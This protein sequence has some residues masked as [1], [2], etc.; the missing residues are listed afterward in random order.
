MYSQPYSLVGETLDNRLLDSYRVGVSD[1]EELSVD[2]G[3]QL[4]SIFTNYHF[5]PKTVT[6]NFTLLTET[7]NQ[8]SEVYRKLYKYSYANNQK[9]CVKRES[10]SEHMTWPTHAEYLAEVYDRIFNIVENSNQ[11]D[12]DHSTLVTRLERLARNLFVYVNIT[13]TSLL[14]KFTIKTDDS[15]SFVF[16]ELPEDLHSSLYPL[17]YLSNSLGVLPSL[18][19]SVGGDYEPPDELPDAFFSLTQPET[20]ILTEGAEHYNRFTGMATTKIVS[21][22]QTPTELFDTLPPREERPHGYADLLV[23]A[24]QK[25]LQKQPKKVLAD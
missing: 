14:T 8:L 5:N 20:D 13:R 1:A 18:K 7:A 10:V 22:N 17:W 11:Y 24:Y 15:P 3:R 25:S 23:T 21:N 9:V 4:L 6:E 2:S 19:K 12:I 16:V